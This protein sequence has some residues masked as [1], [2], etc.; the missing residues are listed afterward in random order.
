MNDNERNGLQEIID[1]AISDIARAEGDSFELD[2]MN[3]AGV[4]E[5]DGTLEI[6]GPHIEGKRVHRRSPWALRHARRHNGDQRLRGHRERPA[7][8]GRHQLGGRL[9]AHQ[10]PGLQGGRNAVKNYIAAHANLVPAKRRLAAADPRV[11]AAGVLHIARGGHRWTGGSS[12]W[13]TGWGDVQDRV[14]RNGVPPLR[15]LL[16]GVLS[17]RRQGEPVHR[18]DPRV[19]GDGRAGASS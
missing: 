17:Q 15:H 5:K 8:R 9:R 7:L 18:H 19:R 3:L 14:L 16:R 13:R 12:T 10:E 11:A 4:L 6:E 2:K 1:K